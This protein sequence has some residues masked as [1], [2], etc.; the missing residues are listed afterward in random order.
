[1]LTSAGTPEPAAEIIADADRGLARGDLYVDSGLARGDLYVGSG[2]LRRL[3]GRP[4]TS[5]HDAVAAAL[6]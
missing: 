6:R 2:Q 4:T 5:R 3:I 1:L